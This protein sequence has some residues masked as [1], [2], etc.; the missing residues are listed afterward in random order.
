M[1]AILAN[2]ASSTLANSIS[3]TAT[4]ISVNPGDGLKF[5]TLAAGDWFPLTLTKLVGGAPVREVVRVTS[6]TGDLF[7][8]VRAREGTGATTFSAGDK[9]S[10]NMTAEA[11][12]GK[13]DRAGGK[14]DGPV[15]MD[16]KEFTGAV[17]KDC[18]SK[19]ATV[20]APAG[21]VHTIDY[22]NGSYQIWNPPAGPCTLVIENWPPDGING[23]LWIEGVN[24][25]AATITTS[26][27]LDY[28]KPDGTYATTNSMN[29]NQGAVLRTS[30]IDNVLIWGREGAPKR[31][32][33]AR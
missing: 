13:M 11:F 18:G 20:G 10:L 1:S 19:V 33:V 22:R 6:R 3:A 29:T 31:A 30:G 32:K 2:N 5:P 26:V 21:T 23:E 7:T 24:L 17:L 14:F 27:A 25:G 12:N 8:I 4:S 28:L 16:D 15:D 9:I